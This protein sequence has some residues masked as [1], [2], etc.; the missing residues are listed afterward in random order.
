VVFV[1]GHGDTDMVAR[2]REQVP[3]RLCAPN[4][5]LMTASQKQ[6]QA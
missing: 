5:W 6:L 3:G 4:Q 1:T 2:I